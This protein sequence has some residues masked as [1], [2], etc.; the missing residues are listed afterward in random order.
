MRPVEMNAVASRDDVGIVIAG[1]R[2]VVIIKLAVNGEVAGFL[3]HLHDLTDHVVVA[4]LLLAT[5]ENIYADD[6][7]HGDYSNHNDKLDHG[8]SG[9]ISLAFR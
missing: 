1:S 8:E 3:D 6:G 7:E 5:A 9:G 2:I 4:D